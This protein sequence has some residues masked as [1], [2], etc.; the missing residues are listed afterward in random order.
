LGE[1]RVTAQSPGIWTDAGFVQ[2]GDDAMHHLQ[3]GSGKPLV[4]LHKL[5]G[6]AR[7]WTA[8]AGRFGADRK[9][10]AI[11][12]PGHGDSKPRG[13]PPQVQTIEDSAAKVV[14]VLDALH[15]ERF[16]LAGA[17]LGGAVAVVVAGAWRERVQDLFLLNAPLTP[18]RD[19]K[20]V[21]EQDTRTAPALWGEGDL[22]LPRPFDVIARQ[23]GVHDPEVHA[24]MNASRGQAG[25]WVR[26]S[27][28]GVALGEVAGRL[29][30]ITAR[31]LVLFGERL[32]P[33]PEVR[34]AVA[35]MSNAQ[36]ALIPNAGAFPHQENPQ[37]VA[38][39]L[40]SV[41]AR[42]LP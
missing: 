4:L 18:A 22:P 2:I 9:V 14:E 32:P 16:D 33:R 15:I 12:L 39:A 26:A 25:P 3:R 30:H 35:T 27:W 28:R 41:P 36:L 42:P 23:L 13:P 24:E 38:E 10:I 5:G 8:L 19:W 20:D 40:A 21:E 34:A 11:D 29:P 6:W 37:A 17:S 31:T 1:R 7:E